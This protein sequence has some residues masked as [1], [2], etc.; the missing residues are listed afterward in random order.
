M[1]P[2][3]IARRLS[4]NNLIQPF[5]YCKNDSNKVNGNLSEIT[6]IK[7]NKMIMA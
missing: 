6:L 3:T 1:I 5:K 4:E 2:I 7:L